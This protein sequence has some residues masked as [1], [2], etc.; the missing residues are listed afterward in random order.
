MKH[1]IL[2]LLLVA[3]VLVAWAGQPAEPVKSPAGACPLVKLKADSLPPLNISRAG[4]QVF[5]INGEDVVAGGHT[6]GFALT[7]Q[8]TQRSLPRLWS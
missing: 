4:H 3:A 1:R 2:F 7:A 5:C 8:V 6:N